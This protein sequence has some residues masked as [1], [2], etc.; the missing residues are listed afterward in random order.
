MGSAGAVYSLRKYTRASIH[1]TPKATPK[2]SRAALFGPS[3]QMS[4][5]FAQTISNHAQAISVTSLIP[6]S[7]LWASSRRVPPTGRSAERRPTW[8]APLPS[9]IV[10]FR[11]ASARSQLCRRW[12]ARNEIASRTE[13]SARTVVQNGA[14]PSSAALGRAGLLSSV[15]DDADRQSWPTTAACPTT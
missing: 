10:L 5:L 9:A 11:V 7:R 4:F 12:A 6:S 2:Q 14:Q 15:V 1:Y 8:L 13:E 3:D